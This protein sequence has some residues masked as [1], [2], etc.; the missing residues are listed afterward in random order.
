[1]ARRSGWRCWAAATAWRCARSSSTPRSSS[2]TLVELDPHMTRLFSEHATLAALNGGALR[3]PKLRIV[4][5]DAFQWLQQATRR[6]DVIVVDFPDP[7]NFAI[8]KLYTNSFYALLDQRLAASGYAV[9]QTTSPLDRAQELLDGGQHHRIG[10]PHRDALPRACAELWRMG[11]HRRQPAALAPARARCPRACAS[12]RATRLPLLFGFP[13]DMARVPAEV[14]R[15]VEPGAG[16]APTSR[17][18]ASSDDAPRSFLGAAAGALAL[19]S[20]CEQPPPQS[21]AASPA[22]TWRAAMRCATVRLA[23]STPATTRRTRVLIAG[24]GV[25]GLAAARALRLAG[26]DDF[27]LLELEDSAGGNSRGGTRRRPACPLGAHY[28]PVPGDDAREVQDLLEELGLRRRVAG[29][30]TYDERHLCHSPQERLYFHGEWQEGLLPLQGV[31][32]ATLAQYRRF[33][34]LVEA[35]RRACALF[36]C[37]STRTAPAPRLLA[38][39]A[40]PL[41]ALARP[42]GPR[43]PAPALVPGLLLPRRLRC[44]QR[45]GLGL[46]RAP[47]LRQPPRLSR[48]RRRR[49]GEA[50]AT[51][52]SP[53]PRATPGSRGAWRSRW[54]SALQAGMSSR[55]S[56]QTR[57]ASR[58][59]PSTPPSG[60]VRWQAERCIVALPVFVA[61][62]VV[63]G[64]PPSCCAT[65]PRTLRYAPWLVANVHLRAPLAD[66]PGAAPSWDNVLYGSARPRLRRCAATSASTRRPPPPCSAGTARSA[67]APRRRRRPPPAAG[68]PWSRLARRAA[69]RV[70]G[71]APRLA[72]TWRPASTSPATAMRWPSRA[73]PA[74]PR[75][76][77]GHAASRPGGWPSR[78]PTGRAIR[79]SRRP[80]RAGTRPERPRPHVKTLRLR[81]AR[82]AI[83]RASAPRSR[84]PS[85]AR[86]A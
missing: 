21:R 46:G 70:D 63:E 83:N 84:R 77:A 12:S 76:G 24:G 79:S 42:R 3:S 32:A 19:R 40:H 25:A 6:Y 47:L 30:W 82:R 51:R 67:P 10:G 59:M 56:P 17:S 73:G 86:R 37:R 45:A 16:H 41:R 4:N 9:V 71:A 5:A 78:M 62:R 50:S 43:R 14:N 68:A 48:A 20:G 72:A 66:R 75:L 33:D 74:A 60:T 81:P 1:M 57:T 28:L 23:R 15:L 36:D 44:R 35:L 49:R 80:S 11:L 53:G 34:A 31:P 27:V 85:P 65:P 69:G 58:S 22:S 61:A 8:G 38:L 54:A 39:D 64:T 26:I 7:T 55:A 2:V 13:Q 52:C 29:R 18:G